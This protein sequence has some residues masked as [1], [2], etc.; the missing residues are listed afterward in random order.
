MRARAHPSQISKQ[1]Y[2]VKSS[3]TQSF[4]L[5]AS[6][7]VG[8]LGVF[9]IR[10]DSTVQKFPAPAFEFSAREIAIDDSAA[11]GGKR[12]TADGASPSPVWPGWRRGRDERWRIMDSYHR[13]CTCSVTPALFS[14]GQPAR[15]R[16]ACPSSIAPAN[17][18][19]AHLSR[20]RGTPRRERV[21]DM[22]Q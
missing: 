5:H 1:Q 20:A 22:A 4:E 14:Y 16:R 15:V 11:G 3:P 13:P 7:M 19:D 10:T 6:L 8:Y 21:S 2:P 17:A 18:K 9:G 12:S